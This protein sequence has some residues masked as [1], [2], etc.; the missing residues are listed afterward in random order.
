M[1]EYQNPF[2]NTDHQ[3]FVLINE[4]AQQSLW[5]NSIH[6]PDG[7]NVVFGPDER[8]NCITFLAE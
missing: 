7:W 5:P 3:F 1:S 4:K 6:I 8:E 2:D